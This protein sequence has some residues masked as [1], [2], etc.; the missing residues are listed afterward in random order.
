MVDELLFYLPMVLLSPYKLVNIPYKVNPNKSIILSN[1]CS[2]VLSSSGNFL[3]ANDVVSKVC[4]LNIS[5]LLVS[6]FVYR[7]NVKVNVN[8]RKFQ[9]ATTNKL[10]FFCFVFLNNTLF[11]L[12]TGIE[13]LSSNCINEISKIII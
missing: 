11:R 8:A 10:I 3:F 1:F 6:H 2:S 13:C 9:V 4:S 5:L 12:S 7:V